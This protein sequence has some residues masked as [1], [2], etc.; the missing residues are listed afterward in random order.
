MGEIQVSEFREHEKFVK[1]DS[2]DMDEFL[3][4]ADIDNFE[5]S[6]SL[7]FWQTEKESLI[8]QLAESSNDVSTFRVL[9]F[10]RGGLLRDDLR[11]K[12]WPKILNRNNTTQE[13]RTSDDI[14]TIEKHQYYNQVVMDVRRIL[15]RFPPGINES[16]QADLQIKVTHLIVRVLIKNQ[17]L[18]YYQGFHDIA[19]T[20]LLVLGEE[21]SLDV[22]CCLSRSHFDLYMGPN[23]EPTMKILNLVYV[24]IRIKNP[25]LYDYLMRAELGTI[26]CLPWTITWFG[27]VLNTYETVVRLFD[28]FICTHPWTSIYLSA[29]I[30]LHRA[31][32]I[33][34]TPCEMPLLHHML[35][36]V[37]EDLPFDLLLIE[38]R[39]LME[40]H[41][42][43]VI[44][45]DV[46]KMHNENLR[47]AQEEEEELR[48]RVKLRKAMPAANRRSPVKL[49]AFY[50]NSLRRPLRAPSFKVVALS[51]S[52][53]TMA[54]FFNYMKPSLDAIGI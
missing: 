37:P 40:A 47:R 45:K 18:H 22:L 49:W 10:T 25:A 23:M 16:I 15:K 6:S 13:L 42:P 19:I 17:E 54:W 38:T 33:F 51:I 3:D 14:E 43:D 5:E 2:S 34:K 46:E 30:V 50:W 53:A 32:E 39:K 44:E 9:C 12:L 41:P 26:F 11:L 28:V 8:N 29:I 36:N 4:L 35:S 24:L 48:K 27:H 7:P 20:L 21:I 1:E 31:D 52:V